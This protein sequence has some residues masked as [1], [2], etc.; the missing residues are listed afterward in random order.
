MNYIYTSKKTRMEK[1]ENKTTTV[2]DLFF[3]AS[4]LKNSS[5]INIFP[6]DRGGHS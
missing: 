2:G 1:Q 3:S 5:D 6:C 4:S